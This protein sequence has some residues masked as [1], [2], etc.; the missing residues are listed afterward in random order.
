MKTGGWLSRWRVKIRRGSLEAHYQAVFG[1]NSGDVVLNDLA[2]KSGL[3]KEMPDQFN[4]QLQYKTGQRDLLLYI[5]WRLR[6]RPSELQEL[7]DREVVE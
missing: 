2:R 5:L 7:A 4:Q 6:L 3:M 1:G